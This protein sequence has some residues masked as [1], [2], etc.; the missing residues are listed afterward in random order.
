MNL[1]SFENL[2]HLVFDM[3]PWSLAIPAQLKW[4]GLEGAQVQIKPEDFHLE[5]Q[6]W[7]N[8][9]AM[10]Q[11]FSLQINHA[12]EHLDTPVLETQIENWR[13]IHESNV[14][15]VHLRILES[16]PEFNEFLAQL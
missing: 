16:S 3:K 5:P 13:L 9:L 2:V 8:L 15:H 7:Q 6:D 10:D 11:K 4:I 12:F 14:L 1:K